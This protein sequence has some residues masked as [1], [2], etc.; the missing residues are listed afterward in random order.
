M[1]DNKV[2]KLVKTTISIVF[3]V[4]LLALSVNLFL[5]PHGI[6]AGG[7]TGLAII[8]EKAFMIDR[9]IV[10]S[11]FN[12]II[13]V[14]TFIF[15]GK[16]VFFN[17][18]LGAILLPI[19]IAIVP[20]TMI[21]EN[22]MLSV[23]FGSVIFG[24]GIA[25]LF[26]NEASAGGTSIP[27]LIFKKYYDLNTSVG[28][29]ATDF[30]IVTLSIFVFGIESFFFAIFSIFLTSATMNYIENGTNRKKTVFM[31]SD[32]IPEITEKIF[33]DLNR[34]VSLI[35]VKGGYEQESRQLLMLTLPSSDYQYLKNIINTC[36]EKA[37]VIA[38]NVSDM[39]GKGFTYD[40]P[41]V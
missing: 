28:M 11:V 7:V 24:A 1:K 32:K 14:L 10:I 18:V 15:L 6:A 16:K 25:I 19:I 29:F 9:S 22:I 23:I 31:L 17:T 27:P 3:A 21:I 5:A 38:F 40:S 2:I 41:T 37:F 8:L 33:Q 34:G 20:H 13:V 12:M 39:H 26:L 35:P 30:I 36:D 4:T